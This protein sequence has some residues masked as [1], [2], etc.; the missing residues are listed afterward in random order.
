MNREHLR[1]DVLLKVF[2]K[3]PASQVEQRDEHLETPFLTYNLQNSEHYDINYTR[4]TVGFTSHY[5]MLRLIQ[6]VVESAFDDVVLNNEPNMATFYGAR[7]EDLVYA[8]LI[9]GGES[10]D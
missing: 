3:S 2:R 6:H 10:H 9:N 1:Q 5:G 4:S 8:H 7:F